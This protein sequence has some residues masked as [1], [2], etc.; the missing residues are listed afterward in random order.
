LRGGEGN[1]ALYGGSRVDFLD[2]GAGVNTNDGG[3][4]EDTCLNPETATEG[5]INCEL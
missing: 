2:G 5:A 3:E 4:G 1:D